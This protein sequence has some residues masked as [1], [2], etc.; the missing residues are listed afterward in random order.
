MSEEYPNYQPDFELL[1]SPL[2]YDE[3]EWRVQTGGK[4]DE[5]P[6]AKLVPYAGSRA[7]MDR[8]DEALGPENWCDIYKEGPAGG[9]LC[10]VGVRHP[11]TGE[12]VFKQDG[13]DNRLNEAGEDSGGIKGGLTDAFKRA[14]VKWNVGHIR[15]LYGVGTLWADINPKGR[16]R[17]VLPK[18]A[19][20]TGFRYDPPALPPFGGA[21]S[22]SK[23]GSK[24]PSKSSKPKSLRSR[25]EAPQRT[26]PQGELIRRLLKS[27]TLKTAE[28]KR[29]TEGLNEETSREKATEVIEWL[30]ATIGKREEK[31]K[32]QA[33]ME[34]AA[35]AL[36]LEEEVN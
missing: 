27:H 35:D 21:T 28:V 2:A 23:S 12:W 17:G 32:L 24:R 6:W 25:P 36:D 33:S 15:A 29:L 22:T 4:K 1:Q 31:E 16:F 7:L 26:K 13:A 18:K 19:G 30:K 3:I 8:L 20:G 9:V 10:V 5:K 11:D 34:A 14:C